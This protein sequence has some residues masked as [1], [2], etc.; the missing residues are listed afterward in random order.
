MARDTRAQR[1]TNLATKMT[2]K[3]G[4]LTAVAGR[5]NEPVAYYSTGSMAL[6]YM[7]GTM[8]YPDNSMVEVYGAPSIGKTS[9]FAY[10]GVLRSVQEA[11]GLTAIIGV[12][13][14]QPEEWMETLGVDPNK[15][16]IFRPN[17]GEDAWNI[18]F[19]LVKDNMVDYFVFDSI[20]AITSAKEQKGDTPQAFGNAALNTWGIKRL[21]PYAW[22][23]HVGGLF[24]NQLRDSK[25]M[26]VDHDSSG[27]HAIKH[28]FDIRIEAKRGAEK[29]TRKVRGT[30]GA[31]E[32]LVTG[33]EVRAI[34]HK[35]KAGEE[36]G[37]RATFNFFNAPTEGKELG[38]DY[39]Q[40]ALTA[41]KVSGIITGTGWLVWD[42]FPDGKVN[43]KEK[44]REQFL[45]PALRAKLRKEV[46][47]ALF[48]KTDDD[49][50]EEA[51]EVDD[52][53]VNDE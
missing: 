24:I 26:Y 28:A 35:D 29:W 50:V 36:R 47:K 15:N 42:G 7:L 49:L 14:N 31:I 1:A 48:T 38:I 6:D 44:A 16:V 52:S 53:D 18:A 21:V 3:Y 51:L 10:S 13:P 17:T 34:I 5:T 2:K 27:G 32:E 4:H 46:S 12:E 22:K 39:A 19:D 45:D 11:G 43:G 25:E 20:G 40:D 23:N 33:R 9:A 30:N 41:G 37:K 8:G